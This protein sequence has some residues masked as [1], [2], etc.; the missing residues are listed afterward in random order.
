MSV[1]RSVYLSVVLATPGAQIQLANKIKRQKLAKLM[2]F[3]HVYLSTSPN[4]RTAPTPASSGDDGEGSTTVVAASVPTIQHVGERSQLT[5]Q[6]CL[7]VCIPFVHPSPLIHSII[8]SCISYVQPFFILFYFILFY[9]IFHII[10]LLFALFPG[11]LSA[12]YFF[13][14][15][16]CWSCGVCYS[17]GKEA[18]SCRLPWI[19][20]TYIFCMQRLCSSLA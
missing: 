13:F 6:V 20:C 2:G 11:L 8:S 18:L 1:C 15:L 19:T 12:L 10:F 4:Q 3:V 5:Y 9:Y 16:S 17:S 7:C 14:V